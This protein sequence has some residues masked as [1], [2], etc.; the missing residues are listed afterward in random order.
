MRDLQKIIWK[1]FIVVGN[2][3]DKADM[4]SDLSLKLCHLGDISD[5]KEKSLEIWLVAN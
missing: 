4:T 3:A 1:C 2:M 5:P